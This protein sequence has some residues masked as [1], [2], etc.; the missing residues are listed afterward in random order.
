MVNF[1][2]QK[3]I[4]NDRNFYKRLEKEETN[5]FEI[6]CQIFNNYEYIFLQNKRFL[7]VSRIKFAKK[8][9]FLFFEKKNMKNF[10]NWKD[11]I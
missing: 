10:K 2:N 6:M 3:I 1:T 9:S 7:F 5:S 11:F 8:Y 4:D